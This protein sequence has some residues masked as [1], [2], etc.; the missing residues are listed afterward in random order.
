MSRSFERAGKVRR[1]RADAT[2]EIAP[3]TWRGTPTGPGIRGR[4]HLLEGHAAADA[5]RLLRRKH[6]LLHGMLV[7]LTHRMGRNRVGRTVHAE[8]VPL[9]DRTRAT[10]SADRVAH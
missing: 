10:E 2:V 7:P 9:T 6:P 3:A 1:L 4:A 5:A 8:L